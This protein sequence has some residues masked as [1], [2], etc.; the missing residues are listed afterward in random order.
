MTRPTVAAVIA[1]HNQVAYIAEAVLSFSGQV[2]ETVVI[3]DGSTDGTWELL[4][5]LEIEGLRLLRNDS[6][7]GVSAAYNRAV[8]TA[9][10]TVVLIQGGDDRSLP[11]RADRQVSELAHTD[12]NLVFSLPLI[13]DSTGRQLP[14]SLASEFLAGAAD[15]DPLPFLF[16]DANYVC[17][18][19]V[20]VRRDDYLALG[21]FRPGLD[22]LQ[23][24]DLWLSLAARGRFVRLEEPVVEYRKHHGNLSREYAALDAPKQRRLA[25]E[26]DNIRRRFVEGASD[27]TLGALAAACHLDSVRFAALAR[28]DQITVLQLSH[29]DKLVVRRGLDALLDV[30]ADDDAPTRLEAMGL[31]YSDLTRFATLADPE[32]LGELA[33]ALSAASTARGTGKQGE[34]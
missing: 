22:L 8:R 27:E 3:D 23:D 15:P 2:D 28:R 24:Y 17:A 12:V 19:S 5:S 29:P 20:A 30:V 16:F 7:T 32:N 18:P 10:S 11:D 25:A 9:S 26:R 4:Q 13:I 1:S 31:T 34:H 33:Q 6:P 21:G 14:Q